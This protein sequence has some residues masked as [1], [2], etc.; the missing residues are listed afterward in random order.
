MGDIGAE[1]IQLKENGEEQFRYY[2]YKLRDVKKALGVTYDSTLSVRVIVFLLLIVSS[3]IISITF[4][5]LFLRKYGNTDILSRNIVILMGAN[6]LL[7]AISEL[8][9][10]TYI[11]NPVL[12]FG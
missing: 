5:V 12:T 3:V 9:I 4:T 8:L 10:L 11:F 7:W 1:K 2:E 6:G